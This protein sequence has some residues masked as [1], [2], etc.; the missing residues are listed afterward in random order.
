MRACGTSATTATAGAG[1]RER[2][3]ASSATDVLAAA[4]CSSAANVFSTSR[5]SSAQRTSWVP[6]SPPASGSTSHNGA[7]RAP[8]SA[9]TAASGD[10]CRSLP[11]PACKRRARAASR[12]ACG[13]IPTT[14]NRYDGGPALSRK[15]IRLR[16]GPGAV[17]PCGWSR[18]QRVWR[19]GVKR[20]LGLARLEDHHRDLAV[21]LGLEVVVGR[22]SRG[23][24]APQLGLSVHRRVSAVSTS[25][26][27]IPH[28]IGC[29]KCESS[30]RTA[31]CRFP[32][33]VLRP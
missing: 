2:G 1:H 17:E 24:D 7:P 26:A 15:R 25:A 22:P 27:S 23:H 33:S 8:A 29:Q 9:A 16:H 10:T 14:R 28:G 20:P 5:S 4:R 18:A 13:T 19:G 12:T 30:S 11:E 6:I 32:S 21:G 31:L 3:V